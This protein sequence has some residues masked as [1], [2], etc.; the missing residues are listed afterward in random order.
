MD[1]GEIAYL[2]KV[3]KDATP[4]PWRPTSG[5]AVAPP[6]TRWLHGMIDGA[7]EVEYYGG[8]LVF[9]SCRAAD[10][11]AACAAMEAL[12]RA[13]DEIERLRGAGRLQLTRFADTPFGRAS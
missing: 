5:A 1:A 7:D 12:P 3:V 10:S 6:L 8:H 4:G 2:R 13:L 11:I 9:E